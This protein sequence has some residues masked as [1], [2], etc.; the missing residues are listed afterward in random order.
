MSSSVDVEKSLQFFELLVDPGDGRG[1]RPLREAIDWAEVIRGTGLGQRITI[2]SERFTP[3]MVTATLEDGEEVMVPA[4]GIHR[5]YKARFTTTEQDDEIVDADGEDVGRYHQAS[6]VVFSGED[7]TVG[8]SR[9]SAS[10]AKLGGLLPFLAH[11]CPLPEGHVWS[12]RPRM[13]RDALSALQA[14]GGVDR[15]A[16]RLPTDRSL[17]QLDTPENGPIAFAAAAADAIGDVIVEVTIT[18]PSGPTSASVQRAL[19]DY[20]TRDFAPVDASRVNGEDLSLPPKSRFTART[21]PDEGP[22]RTLRLMTEPLAETIQVTATERADGG[23][24]LQF[25]DLVTAAA[26]RFAHWERHE[27]HRR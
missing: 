21:A 12:Y 19:R 7:A 9:G 17:F 15:L 18:V 8:I 2:G 3:R 24:D 1:P 25:S 4:V 20:A 14:V 27:K 5:P 22:G 11:A 10:A 23:R 26:T 13:G 16:M 6:V